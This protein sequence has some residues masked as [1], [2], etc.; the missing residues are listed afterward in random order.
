M[1]RSIRLS[2]LIAGV[3]FMVGLLGTPSPAPAIVITNVDAVI[4]QLEACIAGCV[5]AP[6]GGGPIWSAAA[7]LVLNPGDTLVVTQTGVGGT[8][9]FNFDS[10][11]FNQVNPN[12]HCS[13]GFPCATTLSINGTP[14]GLGGQAANSI[15][16]NR[17]QDVDG[18]GGLTHQEANDWVKV[19]SIT[20][21]DIYFGYVDNLHS[22]P[23]SDSNGNCVPDVGDFILP[24]GTNNATNH[25]IGAGT[26]AAG[27]GVPAL[28]NPNHC[29]PN[30]TTTLCFDAGAIL[31]VATRVPEPSSLLLLGVSLVGLSGW[32]I[33][34]NRGKI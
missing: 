28:G 14:V 31:L 24:F 16:A 34:R 32:G 22:D 11:D 15:L 20:G 17:N 3:I 27:L 33:W 5:G 29:N 10:S 12:R 2:V 9:G 25:F 1:K 23:C 6:Q 13:V 26:S 7:N 4:G 30:A 21:L 8:Q 18:T 19:A